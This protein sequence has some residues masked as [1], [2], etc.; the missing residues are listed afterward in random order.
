MAAALSNHLLRRTCKCLLFLSAAA[1]LAS[2]LA[3]CWF[4]D[5]WIAIWPGPAWRFNSELRNLALVAGLAVCGGVPM[6][7]GLTLRDSTIRMCIYRALRRGGQC[8]RCGY[9]FVG[10]VI[11]KSLELSC[12]EC[13]R[14]GKVHEALTVLARH[15]R[16]PD[17][18][19]VLNEA[20]RVVVREAPLLWNKERVRWWKRAAL[21]ASAAVVV[22]VLLTVIVFEA[23]VQ[24][25]ASR[26]RAAM[27]TTAQ[28]QALVQSLNP[29]ADFVVQPSFER[30]CLELGEELDR[31]CAQAQT[32]TDVADFVT[33][34]YELVL[35][36]QPK[37]A[38]R[39]NE[40]T[41]P[42]DRLIQVEALLRE[43]QCG[44]LA[45]RVVDLALAA[46][47]LEGVSQFATPLY[48][49]RSVTA[50]PLEQLE[51]RPVH[52]QD[53]FA[54]AKML[55]AR[56]RV[57]IQR[58]DTGTAEQ[59][60]RAL[61][62]MTGSMREQGTFIEFLGASALESISF[63]TQARWLL[64]S[65][66]ADELSAIERIAAM[67]GPRGD[68]TLQ[69][70][71]QF[72]LMRA[73]I[74][75]AYGQIHPARMALLGEWLPELTAARDALGAKC[76]DPGSWSANEAALQRVEAECLSILQRRPSEATSAA[77]FNP[78]PGEPPLPNTIADGA[79]SLYKSA[80]ERDV[81]QGV[82][83][84]T[85]LT[86][87]IALE[88]HRLSRG[89]YPHALQELVPDFLPSVP[90]DPWSEL[91]MGYRIHDRGDDAYGRP[92]LLYSHGINGRDDGGPPL[93]KPGELER[94]YARPGWHNCDLNPYTPIPRKV[95]GSHQAP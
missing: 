94:F 39:A 71:V 26:A 16:M 15:E 95:P 48:Q 85:V 22:P 61:A 75:D 81:F 77:Y 20:A 23:L 8:S 86:T 72:V 10:L 37:F 29:G 38:L 33:P 83:Q 62:G 12:P 51:M 70:R 84:R 44:A 63:V 43:E 6:F 65:P 56:A 4:G 69:V 42:G 3:A 40:P 58:G 93:T 34:W 76:A 55:C 21:I 31:L 28:V 1:A 14:K 36:D 32:S 27:P 89:S 66:T 50:P 53:A 87:M 7:V 92:Y 82:S 45:I 80:C 19:A 13:G 41:Y 2:M 67:P 73:A 64:S 11:P 60:L 49:V 54:L 91:P 46:G 47:A 59:S 25:Q 74:A 9:T 5:E 78:M 52:M 68:H 17:R 35:S 30:L 88:R 24:Y 18:G 79:A 90:Q 57:A